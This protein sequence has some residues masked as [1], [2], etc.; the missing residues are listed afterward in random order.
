[1]NIPK[2]KAALKIMV[3]NEVY[4]VNLTKEKV[5]VNR[6]TVVAEFYKGK[7]AEQATDGKQSVIFELSSAEDVVKVGTQLETL[8]VLITSKQKTKYDE[9]C[10]RYHSMTA[11]PLPGNATHLTLT[12]TQAYHFVLDPLPVKTE[13]Q[14]TKVELCHIASAVPVSVW[15]SCDLVRLV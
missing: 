13:G 6:G 15:Q 10:V 8:N 1:M 12:S 7:W 2:T 9:A 11:A 14:K 3:G 4:L 5:K